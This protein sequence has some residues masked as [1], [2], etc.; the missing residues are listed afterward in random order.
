MIELNSDFTLGWL[1]TSLKDTFPAPD[2]NQTTFPSWK[3]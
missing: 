2:D 1:K 3:T